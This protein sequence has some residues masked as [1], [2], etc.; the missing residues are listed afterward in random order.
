MALR[1]EAV[2][3]DCDD[4][5]RV[6]RFWAAA[7]GREARADEGEPDVWY[8][9]AGDS[10]PEL[11][12]CKVP[13]AKA[14]KNRVHLDL[15]PEDQAAEVE[16]LLGLGARHVDIGQ[17]GEETWVVLADVEGNEFCVLR[18]RPAST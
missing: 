14:V 17:T 9:E 1:V 5:G 12:F 7:L 11:I 4:P 10:G 13:E 2:D 16:R 15:R 3:F 8:L 6:A 18:A